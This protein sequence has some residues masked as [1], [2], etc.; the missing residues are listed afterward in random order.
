[1]TY[2][3]PAALRRLPHLYRHQFA[4]L[5][6]LLALVIVPA[7]ANAQ[8]Y[9]VFT[10]DKAKDT[11]DAF[12]GDGICADKKGRC[13][14]R[15]AIGEG[16]A[17]P[18]TDV[19]HIFVEARAITV[20]RLN[21]NP[22]PE[23]GNTRGDF[24]VLRGMVIVGQG[25]HDNVITY[26][27]TAG[28]PMF[29]VYAS[30]YVEVANL[31]LQGSG[32]R[33]NPGTNVG[34]SVILQFVGAESHAA[35]C[36][37]CAFLNVVFSQFKY[38]DAVSLHYLYGA[39]NVQLSRFHTNYTR[40][41]SSQFST[42]SLYEV[43][44]T[45]NVSKQLNGAGLAITGG[46][47][48]LAGGYF[49]YNRA[50][51][52]GG[53]LFVDGNAS[54]S[55][56][57]TT[58]LDNETKYKPKLSHT[59]AGRGGAVLIT[60]FP[61]YEPWVVLVNSTFTR[62]RAR[63]GSAVQ[64]DGLADVSL[65]NA[66]LVNN[67]LVPTSANY[68]GVVQAD[69]S[70]HAGSLLLNNVTMFSNQGVNLWVDGANGTAVVS[71]SV[72]TGG[73]NYASQ[74]DNCHGQITSLGNNYSS[75][76]PF[77]CPAIGSDLPAAPV[78]SFG[79]FVFPA[80]IY[81]G[82]WTPTV[83]PLP[84]SPLIDAG[85]PAL[86][87]TLD[88]RAVSRHGVCDI[89]AHEARPDMPLL[90]SYDSFDYIYEWTWHNNTKNKEQNSWHALA[91][92]IAG[93]PVSYFGQCAVSLKQKDGFLYRY[94]GDLDNVPLIESGGRLLASAMIGTNVGHP[95]S[96]M[97]VWYTSTSG[98]SPVKWTELV[99]PDFEPDEFQAGYLRFGFD[100]VAPV[101]IDQLYLKIEFVD[102]SGTG[103][104]NFDELYLHY[105]PPDAPRDAVLPPPPIPPGFRGQSVLTQKL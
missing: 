44:F 31:V 34:L 54:V 28:E 20:T 93:Y 52:G 26:H 65:R 22:L 76:N 82:H 42:V 75:E 13:T 69:F 66:T 3:F 35:S 6:L 68:Q 98:G 15:A 19:V 29:D 11:R 90:L 53:A 87:E 84:G 7:P 1:M 30:G 70:A 27:N 102:P 56:N 62:N 86:C 46:T 100:L 79:E 73:Y 60:G 12:P 64:V 83:A 49:G 104:V 85:N 36:L 63:S 25:E 48:N 89:G 50:K 92:N 24:D 67:N 40:G 74:P 41:M 59:S 18:L 38:N 57:N 9:R 21:T 14:L 39:G 5:A 91:C 2:Q 99:P 45:N 61:P 78:A 58:F 95:G 77:D 94:V 96:V 8:T 10:V 103:A 4:L 32:V 55:I 71:N 37:E 23:N 81:S 17:T 51:L 72:L 33:A 88:Q 47:V 43:R 105:Y 101:D 16:N 97:E 80:G